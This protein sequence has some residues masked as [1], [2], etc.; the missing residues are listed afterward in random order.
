MV[1]PLVPVMPT[2]RSCEDGQLKN[3]SAMRP[4]SLVRD[5]RPARRTP[6]AASAG[7]SMPGPGSHST[8]LAPRAAASA[9]NASP[10]DRPPA[11]SEEEA[12]GAHL[13][14]VEREVRDARIV[15]RH[16]RDAVEKPH[17]GYACS[18]SWRVR[19]HQLRGGHVLQIV[20]RHIH[21]AQ[22]ART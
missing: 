12:A 5:R 17:Q 13:A 9:A 21:Q 7:A 6:P 3:R 14:A 1:L 20:G 4:T 18:C 19:L 15:G 16:R 8:A 2:M 11:Q 22:R 10:C